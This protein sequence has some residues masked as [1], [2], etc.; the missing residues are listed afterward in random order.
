MYTARAIAGIRT[1]MIRNHHKKSFA[2]NAC[3]FCSRINIT[4][5]R[6]L[7]MDIIQMRRRTITVHVTS[8]IHTVQLNEEEGWLFFFDIVTDHGRQIVVLQMLLIGE[9]AK[10]FFHHAESDGI[11]FGKGAE[12]C[13][14]HH[15][16]NA[17]EK[18]WERRIR[19]KIL[20]CYNG[21]G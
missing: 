1:S 16:A 18:R 20:L 15:R 9:N 3:T 21:V 19:W 13:L 2:K 14:G 5:H 17:T 6:I 10:P 7:R 12:L 8:V 4:K 11:P